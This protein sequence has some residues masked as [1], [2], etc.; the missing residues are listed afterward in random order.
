MGLKL[1][2]FLECTHHTEQPL[3]KLAKLLLKVDLQLLQQ[4]TNLTL[5]EINS[6]ILPLSFLSLITASSDFEDSLLPDP[7]VGSKFTVFSAL[8]V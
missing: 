2:I 3:K 1:F 5:F 4:R 7:L 6:Q 8:V